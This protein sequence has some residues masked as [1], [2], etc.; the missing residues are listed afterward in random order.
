MMK[1][2]IY[3]RHIAYLNFTMLGNSDVYL[4]VIYGLFAGVS[5]NCDQMKVF[6]RIHVRPKVWRHERTLAHAKIELK[7]HLSANIRA[8]VKYW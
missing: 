8:H 2:H 7:L 3:P 6:G 1:S 4:K 5:R